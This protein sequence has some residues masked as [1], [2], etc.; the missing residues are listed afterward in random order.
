MVPDLDK[1][2]QQLADATYRPDL[3]NVGPLQAG[4]RTITVPPMGH[5]GP[6]VPLPTLPHVKAMTE[7]VQ[8]RTV[9]L[10]ADMRVIYETL[11]G[12]GSASFLDTG[13]TP[14]PIPQGTLAELAD[15]V[16]VLDGKVALMERLANELAASL[17]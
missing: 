16:A 13:D 3:Q 14:T 17:T 9:K 10:V 2:E 4:T 15:A 6:P 12:K 1:L 5:N 11:H 8:A 7:Q